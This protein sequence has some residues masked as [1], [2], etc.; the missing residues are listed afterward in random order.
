MPKILVIEDEHAIAIGLRDDLRVEGYEVDLAADG[1]SGEEAALTGHYDLVILDLMLPR[2][3]GLS[4]CRAIR[5]AGLR[6]PVI[7]LT[8][9]TQEAEKVLGFELGADDYVTKP[10]G[11][12]EL[13]ARVRAVLRRASEAATGG[14]RAAGVLEHGDLRVDFERFETTLGGKPVALT[15]TEYRLLAALVAHRGR[16]LSVSELID[17]VWGKGIALTDRV[18]YTHINK[19]RGKIERD[20]SNPKLI[21]GIRGIGYRFEE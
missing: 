10:F 18:V 19:L 12:R 9:R 17:E 8:A 2:K 1:V 3:D 14:A 13:M 15:R 6:T 4:V 21:T 5:S 16:P 20:P 7:M 11:S